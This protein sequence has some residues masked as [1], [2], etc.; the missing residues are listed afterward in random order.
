MGGSMGVQYCSIIYFNPHPSPEELK[1][2]NNVV[3]KI[4]LGMIYT[5]IPLSNPAVATPLNWNPVSALGSFN[6][7]SDIMY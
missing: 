7:S 2:Y 4:A 3:I 6:M 1:M 5:N